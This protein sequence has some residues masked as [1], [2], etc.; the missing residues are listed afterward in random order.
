MKIAFRQMEGDRC[1]MYWVA[2]QEDALVTLANLRKKGGAVIR[3]DEDKIK[4]W[5]WNSD[6][7]KEK[8]Q[9]LKPGQYLYPPAVTV[10]K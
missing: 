1:L 10:Y 5:D 3:R 6:D 7:E 8:P 9:D 4:A 2:N